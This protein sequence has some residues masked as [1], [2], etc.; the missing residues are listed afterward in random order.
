[1]VWI[2][3]SVGL[4]QEAVRPDS[5]KGVAQND[6]VVTSDVSFIQRYLEEIRKHPLAVHACQGQHVGGG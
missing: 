3:L 5:I 1:M 6:I 2:D 4:Q